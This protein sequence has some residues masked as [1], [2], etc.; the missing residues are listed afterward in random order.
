MHSTPPRPLTLTPSSSSAAVH[1]AVPWASWL[2]LAAGWLLF[3][4][5]WRVVLVKE[6]T[7]FL[8]YALSI[9]GIGV[10]LVFAASVAWVQ[11]NKR[12]ARRGRR[13][14]ASAY[15]TRAWTEDALGR[16]VVLPPHRL[17]TT[18]RVITLRAEGEAKQYEI[19]VAAPSSLYRS[20]RESRSE[21]A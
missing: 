21:A 18:A 16:Q 2:L 19:D 1:E 7:S 11:H 12:L 5:W 15:L 17:L 20:R 9:V 6:S 13:G 14:N 10:V 4:L 3:A 8:L